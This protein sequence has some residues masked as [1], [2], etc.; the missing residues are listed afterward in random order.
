MVNSRRL[1]RGPGT[2]LSIDRDFDP[3]ENVKV[4]RS[5]FVV[6]HREG[7]SGQRTFVSRQN[8]RVRLHSFDQQVGFQKFES[9]LRIG[10]F[11]HQVEAR[12][13]LC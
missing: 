11:V 7:P 10:C 13:R 4:L 8:Y 5:T 1:G 6:I 3:A 2:A 9:S 12:P